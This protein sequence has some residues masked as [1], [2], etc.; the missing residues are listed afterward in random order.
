M[1]VRVKLCDAYKPVMPGR[2]DF[3]EVNGATINECFR[4]LIRK[5]PQLEKYIYDYP[6]EMCEALMIFHNGLSLSHEELNR[7]VKEED[8]IFP[9]MMIGGG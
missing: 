2:P 6:G 4:D 7:P 3:V 1:S 5:Y 8:E 9:L